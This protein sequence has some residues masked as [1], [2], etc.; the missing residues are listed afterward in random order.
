MISKILKTS[1][2]AV[3][4]FVVLTSI[5]CDRPVSN[6]T[7][8]IFS[9]SYVVFYSSIDAVHLVRNP[10]DEL[11]ISCCYIHGDKN[12]SILF[13]TELFDSIAAKHNDT[14]YLRTFTMA[15][16]PG[17]L[18][19]DDGGLPSANLQDCLSIDILSDG[20]WDENHPAGTSL[21]DIVALQ[22]KS[23]RQY[24]R[25][26]YDDTLFPDKDKSVFQD[27]LLS[28][29]TP[30]DYELTMSIDDKFFL[31]FK[32]RPTLDK[33]HMLTITFAFDDGRKR[34][35]GCRMDFPE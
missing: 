30:Q 15:N 10:Q 25:S 34:I 22:T 35:C 29:M 20:D 4:I 21:N 5:Q 12:C 3:M 32:S 14:T 19:S 33:E 9:E 7:V 18:V 31:K 11:T 16:M 23:Y 24:I 27:M 13:N 17:C 28:E 2:C 26:G 6:G 1:A 8:D